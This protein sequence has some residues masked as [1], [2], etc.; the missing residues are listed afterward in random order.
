MKKNLLPVVALAF[1]AVNSFAKDGLYVEFKVTSSMVNGTSKSYSSDGDTRTETNMTVNMNGTP[2]PLD[3]A[4]LMLHSDP[5]IIYSLNE[6]DKTYTATD[7]SKVPNRDDEAEYEIT[8]LGKE[9]VNNYNCTHVKAVNKNTQREMELWLSKDVPHY[10][11]YAA[12]KNKYVVSNLYKQL[13]DKGADGFAVRMLVAEERAGQMQMDLVK[14]E[15][16]NIDASM[17]SL[18]GYTKK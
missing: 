9:R 17:F 15:E 16:R 7:V 13:R 18:G 8:V 5:H 12:I 11:R 14:A 3:R 1:F 4:V 2:R 6:A 10:E